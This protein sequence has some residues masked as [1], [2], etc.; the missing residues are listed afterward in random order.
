[1]SHRIVYTTQFDSFHPNPPPLQ[2]WTRYNSIRTIMSPIQK[3]GGTG[4]FPILSYLSFLKTFVSIFLIRFVHIYI[5]LLYLHLFHYVEI[6]NDDYSYVPIMF[7]IIIL[8]FGFPSTIFL[9]TP[10][11]VTTFFSECREPNIKNFGFSFGLEHI[12]A[13]FNI[14]FVG[15]I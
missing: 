11:K 9:Y 6:L 12:S 14:V 13:N 7:S 5:T 2:V 1:M 10:S 3:P 4:S 15:S 8:I